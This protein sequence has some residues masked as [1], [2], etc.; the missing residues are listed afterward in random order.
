LKRAWVILIISALT[1]AFLVAAAGVS[2]AMIATGV[3]TMPST[4]VV[5]VNALFGGMAFA[6]T[7]QQALKAT[8]ETSAALTGERSI[9]S[10]QTVVKTP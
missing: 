6:R 9:V 5:V 2:S 8:P 1:D 7:I 3:A 10:T 4:P